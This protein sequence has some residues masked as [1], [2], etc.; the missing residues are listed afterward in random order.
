[1]R[2]NWRRCWRAI[3]SDQY[4]IGL[5]A[6]QPPSRGPPGRCSCHETLAAGR[7]WGYADLLD[8]L[9][10]PGY[11]GHHEQREWIGEDLNPE[12]FSV[13]AANAVLGKV[14]RRKIRARPAP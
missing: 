3:H 13:A 11:P 7:P 8:V 9:G 10:D 1:M 12:A 14:F 6:N 5:I 2:R 4:R